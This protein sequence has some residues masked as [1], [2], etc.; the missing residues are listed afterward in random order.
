MNSP[1][2]NS[3]SL[4]SFEFTALSAISFLAF[5]NLSMFY[6]FNAYLEGLGVEAAWRGVLIGL[7]PGTAFLLRPI[8]S[9]WLTPRN[10]TRV[11][12]VGL[13]LIMFALFSYSLTMNLWTLAL[14]RMLHGAGFV[15]MISACV[16]VLVLFIP[17]GRSGQGFG[18]F[19][20]TSLLP[21]ALLPPLVEP[22]LAVI[23][24]ASRV[25]ALFSPLFVPALF[26]LPAVNR[27]VR[28]R[29][30]DLPDRTLQRPRCKDI[31]EDLRTPGIARLLA[32]SLLLFIATTTVFF[33]MKDHLAA[34]GAG[35]PG[36][37]FSFSTGATILVRIACG[38][39]LD[40]VNRA[41]MLALFLVVLSLCFFFFSLAQ[42]PGSILIL[43]GLYGVCLGFVMPQLN[44]AMFVISPHHLRGLNTNMMLF[45]MDAGFWMGPVL[46][47]MLLSV[48]ADYAELFAVFAVLPL[49]GAV[50]AWSLVRMLGATQRSA[51]K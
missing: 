36:L 18:V 1:A 4:L 14:V 33:Y 41:A 22:L 25:Y 6:G 46:A 2:E 49:A 3:S 35:N 48:G 37:F 45:T 23:G 40:K 42:T 30:A 21:Y 28:R 44:A 8:I 10:S 43:A 15:V 5:C 39:I 12:G 16:S 26:L 38:K 19:S 20:I 47:G 7:E 27:G 50:I 17:P 31:I 24:D 11:M 32:A 9:P 13:I 51:E 29:M 34:L